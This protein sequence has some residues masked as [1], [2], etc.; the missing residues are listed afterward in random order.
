MGSRFRLTEP[1]EA[2]IKAAER[3]I[4]EQGL[5]A[6]SDREIARAAGQKNNSAVQYHFGDR[7]GL[8]E[9]I[10]SYRMVP[11]NEKRHEM[12]EV[13][14]EEGDFSI[15]QLMRVLVLP[16]VQHLLE[17]PEESGYTSLLSQLYQRGDDTLIALSSPRSSSLLL[18]TK[19]VEEAL[20]EMSQEEVYIR[21]NFVG[22]LLLNTMATWNKHCR[23]DPEKWTPDYLMEQSEH[24]I[25]FM[26]GGLCS[27]QNC[28]KG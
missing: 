22:T 1:K 7:A 26:A 6:V 27:N 5:D 2:L 12:L 20:P 23:E 25:E 17:G 9:A 18:M 4:A 3:L 14:E 11:L 15:E 13:L 28:S 19:R 8:I 16:Y 21:L 10:L 24:L